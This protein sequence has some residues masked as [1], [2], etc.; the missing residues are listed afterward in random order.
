M[1]K[2]S[3]LVIAIFSIFILS[4][5]AAAHHP[6]GGAGLGKTGPVRTI[7]ASPLQR[8][9]LALALQTE[10]IDLDAFSDDELMEIA[11][12]G[13]D[14]HSVDSIHHSIFSMGHGLT[15]DLSVS[16]KIPYDVLS[17]IREAHSDEPDEVHDHGDSKGIGDLTVFGQYRFVKLIDLDI[18]SSL[19]LGLR[20]PTGRTNAKDKDGE[21]FE[22]EF[23]PGSGA[24]G[25][26]AGIAAT[27]RF[28]A[29]SLDAD[30]LYTFATEGTQETDLGDLFNY[31]LAVSY[32]ALYKPVVLDL[33]VEANG[34]W[35]QKQEIDGVR[36]DNSGG[37]VIFISPGMRLSFFNNWTAYVS[38]GFPVA[39]DLNGEQNETDLRVLLGLGV[40]L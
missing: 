31:D 34:E 11:E 37:T 14:V 39:Q 25:P 2:K 27:K 22:A 17:N 5:N 9:V 20:M 7:S 10:F 40:G 26:I 4:S 30:L 21:R 23:Q 24:W 13:S 28:K 15:D 1:L 32:T 16:L 12:D 38:A 19:V 35:K 3:G 6:T 36:D 18:E 29:L 8:G 33:I